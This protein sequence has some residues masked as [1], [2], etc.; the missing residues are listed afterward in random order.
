MTPGFFPHT[1][2]NRSSWTSSTSDLCGGVF[3]R[4]TSAKN[5]AKLGLWYRITGA[6]WQTKNTGATSLVWGVISRTQALPNQSVAIDNPFGKISSIPNPAFS[7]VKSITSRQPSIPEQNAR[8]SRSSLGNGSPIFACNESICA[9]V[10]GFVSCSETG[11]PSSSI[12]L[13]CWAALI[14]SMAFMVS[15][16]QRPMVAVRS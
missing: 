15:A 12:N 4:N 13:V 6:S 3:M 7:P 5:E 9:E 1:S 11:S 16:I 2:N 8:S 10:S 14:S